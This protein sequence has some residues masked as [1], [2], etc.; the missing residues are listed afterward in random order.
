VENAETTGPLEAIQMATVGEA[1]TALRV[2][3]MSVYRLIHDGELEAIWVTRRSVRIPVTEITGYLAAHSTA[4]R[5]GHAGD[6]A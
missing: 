3:K 2:S 4:H 5:N 1:A 6:A